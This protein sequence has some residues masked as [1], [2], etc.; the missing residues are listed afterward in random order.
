[1]CMW[2]HILDTSVRTIVRN[3]LACFIIYSKDNLNIHTISESVDIIIRH[4]GA[5]IKGN[6]L[7]LSPHIALSAIGLYL[8]FYFKF[9]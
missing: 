1:M 8:C 2:I 9:H 3:I 4:M 5:R 6:I 7:I